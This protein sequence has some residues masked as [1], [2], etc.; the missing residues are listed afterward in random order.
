MYPRSLSA[1]RPSVRPLTATIQWLPAWVEPSLCYPSVSPSSF[2]LLDPQ[3]H[4]KNPILILYLLKFSDFVHLSA[5]LQG[6]QSPDRGPI[7]WRQDQCGLRLRLRRN[8]QKWILLEEVPAWKSKDILF[9]LNVIF[10]W[11]NLIYNCHLKQVPAFETSDGQCIAESNAIAYYGRLFCV[12]LGFSQYLLYFSS[13]QLQ[14]TNSEVEVLW[15]RP[16]SFNGWTLL[17]VKCSPSRAHLFSP[18]LASCHSTKQYGF[19]S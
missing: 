12:L 11:C 9:C 1:L 17:T 7:L 5:K 4:L 6:F 14:M 13:I 3:W 15:K 10:Y 2:H 8:Q 18:S 19:I 16:K